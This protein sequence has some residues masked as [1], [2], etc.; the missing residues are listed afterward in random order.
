MYELCTRDS[1]QATGASWQPARSVRL[2]QRIRTNAWM[3]MERLRLWARP[4]IQITA[5]RPN[6][7]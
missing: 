1:H 5:S 2:E 6:A 3:T 4:Y 7:T